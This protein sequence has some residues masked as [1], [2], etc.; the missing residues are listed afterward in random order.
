M[1]FG[2]SEIDQTAF[3]Q[4]DDPIAGFELLLFDKRT[5]LRRRFG[6][7]AQRDEI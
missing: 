2:G 3:A 6:Q 4:D 7:F 1:A 5:D